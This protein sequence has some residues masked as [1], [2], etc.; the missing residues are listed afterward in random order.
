MKSLLH[1]ILILACFLICISC[2][3]QVKSEGLEVAVTVSKELQKTIKP[4][5]RLL[6]MMVEHEKAEPRQM[7]WPSPRVKTYIFGKNLNNL[8]SKEAFTI[9]NDG[10]WTSNTNTTLAN[11]PK[12]TYGV[13][14][15]WDQDTEESRIN[16]PGNLY[17]K[18][19]LVT[20]D[21]NE[22]L[23]LE[24]SET[25]EPR[26]VNEHPLVRYEE[27][28]SE[29]L[30]KFW[31]KPMYYKATV[32][33]PKNYKEGDGKDYA[34]RYNVSGFGG[35]YTRI[36]RLTSDNDFMDWWNSDDAPNIITVFLDSDGPFGDHY[37]MDSENSGPY[38]EA[39]TTEFI[40][41]LETK[42]RG[43]VDAKTRFVDGC[44]TGGWVSLGL[45][46]YYPEVFNG[47]FSYSPDAI[48]F[49]RYQL[50]NIYKDDN[51]Y[52]NE[53]GYERPIMR[54]TLGEP[55]LSTRQFVYHENALAGSNTYVNSGGQIGSHTALYSPKGRD[56]LPKPLFDAVTG[57][58][59]HEVAKHWEKYDFLKLVKNNWSTLGPK[60]Q[61]KI[62]VW[63]GD[64]DNFYLNMAT[65][66]FA[67]YL[68]T[69]ENPKFDAVIEFSAMEAHCTQYSNKK[70]LKQ[71]EK[72][73]KEVN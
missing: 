45:Q 7:I 16:A 47:C 13:Q 15:L 38:G 28:K 25:I 1:S 37:Q 59:D 31:N 20:I 43:K 6:L 5:G 54:S 72:R 14:V 40:P 49:E 18:K 12:G 67:E 33:L 11:L 51:I 34:M 52:V 66:S 70:V 46:L 61:G 62:Y 65:R 21:G 22:N 2:K 4:S 63:M 71:I 30:S 64:M 73:L 53:Y 41:Y 10:S 23:E 29:A 19:Q 50:T 8:N 26:V 36:N 48:E 44:S 69:T 39:L 55:M 27:F 32:L 35:R 58:I 3:P 17:S 68:E 60:L 56:G 9:T 42:Y 24:I 57:E